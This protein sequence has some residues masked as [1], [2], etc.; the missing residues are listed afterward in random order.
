[1]PVIGRLG[2]TLNLSADTVGTA[3]NAVVSGQAPARR[4]IPAGLEGT[5]GEGRGKPKTP[6][7][8]YEWL[9]FS[10][11][12]PN[13]ILGPDGHGSISAGSTPDVAYIENRLSGGGRPSPVGPDLAVEV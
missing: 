3:S 8:H 7:R 5:C 9:G 4:K 11:D 13:S 2:G 12:H 6:K 1:L 10:S